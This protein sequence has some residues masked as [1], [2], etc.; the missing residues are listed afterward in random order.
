MSPCL[1][2][3]VKRGLNVVRVAT[4]CGGLKFGFAHGV[5][6]QQK[7]RHSPGFRKLVGVFERPHFIF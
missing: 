5:L 2:G 3:V 1:S 4:Q 7:T 6:S